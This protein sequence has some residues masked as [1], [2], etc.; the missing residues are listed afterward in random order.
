MKL[1]HTRRGSQHSLARLRLVPVAA[2]SDMKD[3]LLVKQEQRNPLY[4]RF[5]IKLKI[6]EGV[7]CIYY[8]SKK[9]NRNWKA[10]LNLFK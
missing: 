1:G 9:L 3:E 7:L 4:G 5:R 8:T 6:E 10:I 2:G